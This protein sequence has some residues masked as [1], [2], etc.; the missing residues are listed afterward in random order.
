MTEW[1]L[2][3][4]DYKTLQKRKDSMSAPDTSKFINN[5]NDPLLQDITM[6]PDNI[7]MTCLL[8]KEWMKLTK[9]KLYAKGYEKLKKYEGYRNIILPNHPNAFDVVATRY[10]LYAKGNKLPFTAASHTLRNFPVIGKTLKSNGIFFIDMKGFGNLAYRENVNTYMKSIAD[11]GEWIQFFL[12]GDRHNFERQRKAR[13]GLLKAMV[14]KPCAF[15]PVSVSY[16][17]IVESYIKEIGE[18]YVEFHDP[19]L[20]Q[21][22]QDFDRLERL[23]VGFQ[24]KGVNVYDTDIVA[25]L[26]LFY[27]EMTL[28]QIY[29]KKEWMA[30]LLRQRGFRTISQPVDVILKYL[31]LDVQDKTIKCTH[32]NC[33]KLIHYRERILHTFYDIANVPDVIHNEFAYRSEIK[34]DNPELKV[35]ATFSVKHLVEL[36][37][38]IFLTLA[39]GPIQTASFETQLVTPIT[40]LQMVRNTI[41]VLNS[42]RLININEKGIITQV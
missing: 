8:L 38:R 40:N 15:F 17:Q 7:Y 35:I 2:I 28:S 21:P 41:R 16:E 26:L 10:S 12:E 3:H 20:F 14:D 33:V 30:S 19:I 37:Q 13:H 25:T 4:D 22:G 11:A 18:V 32:D 24:Q 9:V 36:Y 5:T 6:K 27:K 29:D 39:K 23:I 34:I 42:N 31:K 1:T